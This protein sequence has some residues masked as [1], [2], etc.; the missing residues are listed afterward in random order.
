MRAGNNWVKKRIF[1]FVN[2]QKI[3]HVLSNRD[4][5]R[6]W[7]FRIE[8]DL[9]ISLLCL[10]LE[11]NI[12]I[13]DEGDSNSDESKVPASHEHDGDTADG[14]QDREGP[15]VELEA[16]SPVWCL[17]Q[18]EKSAGHIN[19]AITHQEKHAGKRSE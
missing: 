17:E 8:R 14:P 9:H 12:F 16:W 4:G 1:S 19:E 13:N 15:V 7:I 10:P 18:G 3:K 11:F 5:K 2:L 6:F